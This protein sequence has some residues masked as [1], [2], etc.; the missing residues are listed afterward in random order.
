MSANHALL[1][2]IRPRFVEAIFART[3][4]VELRRVR[5]RLQTGD[6]V[7]IYASGT[8]KGIVGAFEVAGVTAATPRHIW[9]RHNGGSGL[10]KEEFDRYFAG[11]DRG[12]AIR[13]GRLWKHPVPISLG[14]LRRRRLGFCPPQGYHYWQRDDLLR[15]GGDGLPRHVSKHRRISGRAISLPGKGNLGKPR[16]A[17]ATRSI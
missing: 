11:T 10:G 14:T 1:I 16:M 8:T 6:L 9:R 3:K 2:S 15:V 12:Y 5:P 13:I 7:V 17:I 4:T